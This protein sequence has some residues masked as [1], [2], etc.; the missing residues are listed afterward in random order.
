MSGGF[1]AGI[2]SVADVIDCL[3]VWCFVFVLE[4]ACYVVGF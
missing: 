1:G 4:I 3:F 2:L